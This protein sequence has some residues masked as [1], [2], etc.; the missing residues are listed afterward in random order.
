MSGLP[1]RVLLIEDHDLLAHTLTVALRAEGVELD[2][3]RP[4]S[5][6]EL[7]ATVRDGGFDLV[8][9]DLEGWTDADEVREALRRLS[10]GGP[11]V[12]VLTDQTAV[13]PLPDHHEATGVLSKD[14]DLAALRAAMRDALAIPR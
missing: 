3:A 7:V 14:E 2:R 10:D 6:A 4:G 11:P 13:D 1:K 5:P 9:L 8:L 12:V